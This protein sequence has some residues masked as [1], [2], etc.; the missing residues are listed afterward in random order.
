[1]SRAR[2]CDGAAAGDVLDPAQ[3]KAVGAQRSPEATCKV[4]MPLCSVQTGSA[5]RSTFPS[6]VSLPGKVKAERAQKPLAR[7]GDQPGSILKEN[8]PTLLERIRQR[9]PK[10]TG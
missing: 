9:D 3:V 7:V 4:R 2:D 5:E 6:L 1:M 10:P 8:V